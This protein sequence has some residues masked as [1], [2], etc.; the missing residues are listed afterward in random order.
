MYT[1]RRFFVGALLVA[2]A[3]GLPPAGAASSAPL[4][5][6][7]VLFG[8][9]ASP[10][11]SSVV[12]P[13]ARSVAARRYSTLDAHELLRQFVASPVTNLPPMTATRRIVAGRPVTLQTAGGE[14]WT[15]EPAEVAET[16]P[17][18]IG[19]P[20]ATAPTIEWRGSH[21]DRDGL[22]AT[23]TF[24]LVP[25]GAGYEL[26][27]VVSDGETTLQVQR[28]DGERYGLYEVDRE[29]QPAPL[30][31]PAQAAPAPAGS[32]AP[33]PPG[34]APASAPVIDLLVA[35][36]TGTPAGSVQRIP[37]VVAET[38][39][40]F[41]NSALAQR[42]RLVGTAA[43]S[44]AQNAQMTTDLSRLQ[45][46]ADGYLDQLHSL[47]TAYGADLVTLIVPNSTSYCGTAYVPWRTG[48]PEW[49]FGVVAAPCL[50]YAY[51]FTHELGHNLGAHHDPGSTGGACSP[52]GYSCGHY[53]PG[54]ARTVMSYDVCSGS[55]PVSLQFS[56]P[57]IDFIGRPGV[58]SGVANARDNRSSLAAVAPY[59]ANYR[60]TG[61]DVSL[62]VTVAS[63][64]PGVVDLAIRST[65]N[66]V[67]YRSWTGAAWTDW[68]AL[69]GVTT[70]DP[71]MSTW[72]GGRIDIFVRGSNGAIFQ[73]LRDG[74]AWSPWRSLGGYLTSGPT[75]ASWGANRI[76][77]FARGG[78]GALWHNVWA[79]SRW[80]G[81]RSLG[82]RI[83]SDPEVVS[84][85]HNRL[86]VFARGGDGGMWRLSWDGRAWRPWQ[87][88]G[89]GFSSGPGAAS[90]SPG[91]FDVF[92]RGGDGALW[93]RSWN[94]V[95]WSGWAP[96]GGSIAS[97]PD[98]TSRQA[99][100][101]DVF[102]P[103]LA[104]QVLQR[105]WTTSSWTNWHSV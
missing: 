1:W 36:T 88:L 79:G 22:K 21:R 37:Q 80:V 96:L 59:V 9:S 81:W 2:G 29:F 65:D 95:G 12:E 76:D 74:G 38:N 53:V 11:P 66:S 28:L 16:W 5:Q 86:D 23:A 56:S 71:D 73:R 44:Y 24:T 33:P 40:A 25:N 35:Y 32:S 100:A 54:V 47:R 90:R 30:E 4:D 98:A 104:G 34:S 19:G 46:P 85:G 15:F 77:V 97:S 60:Q 82:G 83:T 45:H 78:D 75:A 42:V 101:F 92:G 6:A 62:G 68:L 55:C 61:A 105:S 58:R 18:A 91:T 3:L 94:G 51:T 27:G 102:A 84:I 17:V 14:R 39:A 13:D 64:A 87:N 57:S 48:S 69:G 26:A 52:Y 103:G 8:A 63:S 31:S 10:P 43:V 49:G 20:A 50:T 7:P 41:A 99:G 72:G 67:S 93:M 89:G 70:S